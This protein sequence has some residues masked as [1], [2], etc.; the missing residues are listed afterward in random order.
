MAHFQRP[1]IIGER[2]EEIDELHARFRRVAKAPRKLQKDGA[3]AIGFDDG[4]EVVLERL[5]VRVGEHRLLVCESAKDFRREFEV[6]IRRHAADPTLRVSRR[7][8]AIKGRIDLD[9]VEKT[10]EIG[11]MIK[12]RAVFGIDG[13]F[14]I[15]IAP[16]RRS[17]ANR[18]VHDVICRFT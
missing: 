5:H 13:A 12:A 17:D 16:S 7:R 1:R 6:G 3:E 15:R 11:E 14:P 8:D 9:R 4:I 2:F 18:M 10:G